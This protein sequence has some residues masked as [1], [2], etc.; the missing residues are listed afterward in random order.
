MDICY[1]QTSTE[2]PT[3]TEKAGVRTPQT[4]AWGGSRHRNILQYMF[5]WIVVATLTKSKTNFILISCLLPKDTK[6][7]FCESLFAGQSAPQSLRTKWNR[8]VL[9]I[10]SIFLSRQLDEGY[11]SFRSFIKH[12]V[13]TSWGQERPT[14]C[15]PARNIFFCSN[16]GWEPPQSWW[17][18][19]NPDNSM[20][21]VMEQG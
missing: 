8:R 11:T 12:L 17:V 9:Q 16:M 4:G 14:A 20:S 19:D 21:P 18:Q 6:E 5:Y 13:L 1:I 2:K 15:Q 7:L 3:P 10:L